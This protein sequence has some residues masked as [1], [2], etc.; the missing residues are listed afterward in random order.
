MWKKGRVDLA[1]P[2]PRQTCRQIFL[3]PFPFSC[4]L[5][6]LNNF[7]PS[8]SQCISQYE[9][10]FAAFYSALCSVIEEHITSVLPEPLGPSP[11]NLRKMLAD[12]DFTVDDSGSTPRS[13]LFLRVV[14]RAE[15][16]LQEYAPRVVKSD[17]VHLTDWYNILYTVMV[18]PARTK[19]AQALSKLGFTRFFFAFDEYIYWNGL[20]NTGP[21]VALMRILDAADNYADHDCGVVFWHLILDTSPDRSKLTPVSSNSPSARPATGKR[22]LPIWPYMSFDVHAPGPAETLELIKTPKDALRLAFLRSYGRPVGVHPDPYVEYMCL[23]RY[24]LALAQRI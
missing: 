7:Y 6:W 11:D 12:W 8:R 9:Q 19:L 4:E 10:R 22:F 15:K 16:I 3:R 21:L 18:M 13:Q 20:K 5:E 17:S 1:L 24:F 23:T 2:L 14:T